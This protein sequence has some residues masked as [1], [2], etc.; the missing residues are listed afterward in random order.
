MTTYNPTPRQAKHDQ[1][2]DMST[3]PIF[4]V[5]DGTGR[6]HH[7]PDQA[8]SYARPSPYAARAKVSRNFDG[9]EK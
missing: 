5:E 7:S 8:H 6:N 1:V 2:Q 3:Y 4:E 9:A